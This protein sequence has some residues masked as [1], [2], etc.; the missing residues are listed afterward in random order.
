MPNAVDNFSCIGLWF[1]ITDLVNP[2]Y[3]CIVVQL[4]WCDKQ[5][6]EIKEIKKSICVKTDYFDLILFYLHLKRVT[7]MIVNHR[8]ISL[9]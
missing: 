5:K 3:W 1:P 9:L 6:K 7:D 2:N 8:V 4:L